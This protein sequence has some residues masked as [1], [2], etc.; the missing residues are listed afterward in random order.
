MSQ[1]N[2]GHV[3]THSYLVMYPLFSL[4]FA[5]FASNIYMEKCFSLMASNGA[6]WLSGKGY[7]R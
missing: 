4:Q 5:H 7:E 3:N 2:K 1:L 6:F